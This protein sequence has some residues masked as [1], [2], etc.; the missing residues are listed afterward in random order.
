GCDRS[1]RDPRFAGRRRPDRLLRAPQAGADRGPDR[2]RP[3]ALAVR[4]RNPRGL[5]GRGSIGR[6]RRV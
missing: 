5:F 1:G 6:V 4:C 3:A 2:P